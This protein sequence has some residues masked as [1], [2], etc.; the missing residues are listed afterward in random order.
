MATNQKNFIR[1]VP[2]VLPLP[3]GLGW[4]QAGVGRLA[5]L[6]LQSGSLAFLSLALFAVGVF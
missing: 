3:L 1:I 5:F 2:A 4:P 6:R